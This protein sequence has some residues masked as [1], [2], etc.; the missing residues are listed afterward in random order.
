MNRS[1]SNEAFYRFPFSAELVQE[2]G[3]AGNRSEID[4]SKSCREVDKLM[5]IFPRMK[6]RANFVRCSKQNKCQKL[7]ISIKKGKAR[8]SSKNISSLNGIIIIPI[9]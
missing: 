7:E 3:H 9:I 2:R 1:N 4:G 6:I 8:R 5:G